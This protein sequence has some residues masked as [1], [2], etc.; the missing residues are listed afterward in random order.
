MFHIPSVV[1]RPLAVAGA[2]VVGLAAAV[3]FGSPA[4]AHH[5]EVSGTAACVEG[6]WQV[7]WTVANSRE[8][9]RWR[10]VTGATFNPRPS[11]ERHVIK[12]GATL[13]AYQRSPTASLHASRRSSHGPSCA[14]PVDAHWKRGG[15]DINAT[16]S[17]TANDP[18]GRLR[19]PRS[20]R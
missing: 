5:P 6:K 14:T 1:R 12:A 3:A 8:G 19:R 17:A 16:K 2:A 4:S 7:D 15:K 20:R 18:Q 9:P 13:P 11:H 10:H